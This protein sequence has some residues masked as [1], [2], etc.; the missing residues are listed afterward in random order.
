VGV[1]AVGGMAVSQLHTVGAASR[2]CRSMAARRWVPGSASR[3]SAE[4]FEDPA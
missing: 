2:D 4:G 3:K 1:E